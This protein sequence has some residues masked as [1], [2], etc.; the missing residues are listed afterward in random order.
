MQIRCGRRVVA[1]LVS[2][3]S[4]DKIRLQKAPGFSLL[5][6]HNRGGK[7]PSVQEVIGK[8]PELKWGAKLKGFGSSFQFEIVILLTLCIQKI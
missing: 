5:E 7:C 4:I 6:P 1:L 3:T 8:I 2:E